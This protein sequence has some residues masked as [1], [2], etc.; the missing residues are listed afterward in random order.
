MGG[1]EASEVRT[2]RR[3]RL[4]PAERQGLHT[5]AALGAA[6]GAVTTSAA[7][8][9][10]GPADVLLSAALISGASL[11]SVRSDPRT[12]WVLCGIG[13]AAA[14]PSQWAVVGALG[15]ALLVVDL[16]AARSLPLLGAAAVACGATT[17][18]HVPTDLPF[19]LPSVVGVLA[20]APLLG[21]ALARARTSE[22]RV[23]RRAAAAVGALALACTVG[24]AVSVVTARSHILAATDL[25]TD[26]TAAL[27]AGDADVAAARFDE[28]AERFASAERLLRA[29]WT[30]PAR[31]VPV[32][33]QH[34]RALR[35][36]SSAGVD[37]ATA[38]ATASGE[39]DLD[40]LQIDDGTVD[41]VALRSFAPA[42]GRAL[43]AL[44]DAEHSVASVRS[45]WLLPTVGD[46]L[47]ALAAEIDDLLPTTRRAHEAV[48]LAPA[49]L[50]GDGE[51]RYLLAFAN[52]AEARHQGGFIGAFGELTA[53]DG[54]LEL[55]RAAPIEELISAPGA[56]DRF[57]QMPRS[58]HVRYDR[59]RPAYFLQNLTASPDLP[60]NAEAMRQLYP[61][62]G[63]GRI[64]G[65]V[66]VDPAGLAALLALT[67]PVTPAGS[68]EP[69]DATTVEDFLLRRQYLEF[70]TDSARADRL[71]DVARAAFDALTGR[72]LPSPGTIADVLGPAA[73]GGH[74]LFAPFDDDAAALLEEVDARGSMPAT[75]DGGDL[76]S[77]RTANDNPSK[78][79]AFLHRS[80]DYDA[81]WNP[82]T[83]AVEATATI[84][85]RNDAPDGGLPAYVIGNG[86]D[87]P[88]GT[89]RMV[90]GLYSA[91][92]VRSATLDGAPVAV[93]PQ[94]ELGLHVT[95]VP[96]VVPAGGTVVLEL[97][98]TGTVDPRVPYVVAVAH[99]PTVTDDDV[100]VA[101]TAAT[102]R[103]SVR[104]SLPGAE[105]SRWRGAPDRLLTVT[106]ERS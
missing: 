25:A 37:L 64:D 48:R 41:L 28:A 38:A 30:Q 35:T 66:Y 22:R 4:R 47:A 19:P 57:L 8:T 14:V 21:S 91:L 69:I 23:A 46:P 9:G 89:N 31:L 62:T 3:R 60:T 72:E 104:G 77:L 79:D 55:T 50:G 10:W 85:L 11:A 12:W 61:Q 78:I 59:Y 2:A 92:G 54:H 101:V 32:V 16:A 27:E 81:R 80:L 40:R 102:G 52:P 34:A 65:V 88:P 51:R 86:N 70:A 13:T 33:G 73:A 97:E 24:L 99:Q 95:S 63:G 103:T 67:G 58:Y 90:V 20:V 1:G 84:T 68:S 83:G 39:A 93:E 82:D 98:L 42:T 17:L 43:E 96:V 49:L 15:L 36:A 53:V 5:I 45:P 76:V 71:T 18:L 7:P 75:P 6:A 29:P 105:G 106:A 94:R 56:D 44:T 87:D 26:A 100:S 74:L